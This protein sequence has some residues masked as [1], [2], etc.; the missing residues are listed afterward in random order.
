MGVN[1]KRFDILTKDH[2]ADFT[3]P[4]ITLDDFNDRLRSESFT[5]RRELG[6]DDL[7]DDDIS[8]N[9]Q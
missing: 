7:T 2:L 3:S 8:Y 1:A 9:S 5:H 4:Q 6:T